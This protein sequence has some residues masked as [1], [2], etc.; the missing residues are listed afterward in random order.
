MQRPAVLH[1]IQVHTQY[2]SHKTNVMY[3]KTKIHRELLLDFWVFVSQFPLY[4][5]RQGLA[6]HTELIEREFYSRNFFSPKYVISISNYGFL[7]RRS[8][9]CKKNP[10]IYYSNNSKIGKTPEGILGCEFLIPGSYYSTTTVY[11]I[12]AIFMYV[13]FVYK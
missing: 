2:F 1:A 7:C 12:V 8:Q 9:P 4:L 10:Q 11:Y 6:L 5:I 13:M 3:P